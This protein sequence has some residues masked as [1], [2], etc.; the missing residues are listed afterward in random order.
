[1]SFPFQAD[2]GL[3]LVRVELSGPEGS[4]VVRLALDTGATSTL[5]RTSVIVAL[6]Y[7]PASATDLIEVT[8]A[9]GIEYAPRVIIDELGALGTVKRAFPVL[10]HPLPPSAPIDGLLGHDFFRRAILALDFTAGKLTL[11]A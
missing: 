7:N 6:G 2:K 4:L 8:T 10:S 3:I 11:D 9:T 1:V 5:I